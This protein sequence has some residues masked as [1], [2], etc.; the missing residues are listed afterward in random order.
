MKEVDLGKQ[1]FFLL[2]FPTR[3]AGPVRNPLMRAMV[4]MDA[5][6]RYQLAGV[7]CALVL[8]LEDVFAFGCLRGGGGNEFCGGERAPPSLL[9]HLM[10]S[11]FIFIALSPKP[12]QIAPL[13]ARIVGPG[14]CCKKVCVPTRFCPQNHRRLHN[15][16]TLSPP[17]PAT[18]Q[19]WRVDSDPPHHRP[20][21][22]APSASR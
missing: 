2:R 10:D 11:C 22:R 9:I 19:R 15:T 8:T 12:P 14:P 5:R 1:I 6:G 16:T 7:L 13:H 3:R 18:K 17:P 20:P 21:P 4:A